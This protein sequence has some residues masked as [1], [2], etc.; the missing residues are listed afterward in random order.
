MEATYRYVRRF[1][2]H[3]LVLALALMYLLGLI[4]ALVI[5]TREIPLSDK[6]QLPIVNHQIDPNCLKPNTGFCLHPG[7]MMFNRKNMSR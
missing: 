3:G 5:K 6:L 7:N 1:N 4:L 2:L